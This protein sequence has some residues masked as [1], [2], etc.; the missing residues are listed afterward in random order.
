MAHQVHPKGF[1]IEHIHDWSSRGFYEDDYA[2]FLQQDLA[3]KKSLWQELATAG[4]EDINIERSGSQLKVIIKSSRPGLVIGR[5]GE[6]VKELKNK[7]VD[8]LSE[9]ADKEWDINVQIEEVRGVWS[10]ARLAAQWVVHQL[11]KRV[12]YRRAMNQALEKIMNSRGVEGAQVQLA[13]RLNGVDIARTEHTEEGRLP[14]QNLRA[15]IDYALEEAN[16][17]YGTI[18]VKVWIYQGKEFE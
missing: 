14:R 8:V 12:S 10:S 5:G 3:I 1:R 18:G 16:T 11:E 6:R 13:G 17:T 9:L 2:K 15:Q 4:I 7:V